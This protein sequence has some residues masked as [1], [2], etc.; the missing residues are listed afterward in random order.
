MSSESLSARSINIA[1]SSDGS[2]KAISQTSTNGT[3]H[4]VTNAV[5][6]VPK[7]YIGS[8]TDMIATYSNNLPDQVP[9]TA[10]AFFAGV[11]MASISFVVW[12]RRPSIVVS[13]EPLLGA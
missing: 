12:G 11:L 7:E 4:L 8:L 9:T 2:F 13:S 3:G 5:S 6:T 1:A 10:A